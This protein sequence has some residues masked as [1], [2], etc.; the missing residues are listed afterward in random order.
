MLRLTARSENLHQIIYLILS[1]LVCG[2]CQMCPEYVQN[3]W[4]YTVGHK[5]NC[6]L[7]QQNIHPSIHPSSSSLGFLLGSPQIKQLLG[8]AAQHS[9]C[10]TMV[11]YH[12][13]ITPH[14]FPT[15]SGV[16]FFYPIT[17]NTSKN[18]SSGWQNNPQLTD[19]GRET[20]KRAVGSRE[21]TSAG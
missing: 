7:V 5:L 10:T 12:I 15:Q 18:T 20:M 6:V 11:L 19:S 4:R 17:D 14:S 1:V 16:S 2:E 8:P 21:E 9:S 3:E 13:R